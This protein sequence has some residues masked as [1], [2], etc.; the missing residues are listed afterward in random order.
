LAR[1]GQ[2]SQGSGPIRFLKQITIIYKPKK[3]HPH[4]KNNK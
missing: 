1:C 2:R 4:Y 3:I